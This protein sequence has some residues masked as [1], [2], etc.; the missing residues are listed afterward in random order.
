M[1]LADPVNLR[2]L[3]PLVMPFAPRVP[4]LVALF[5]LRL[6]AIE[7][8]E[9]AR[10]WRHMTEMSVTENHFEITDIP[11]YGQVHEV[12]RARMSGAL[13]DLIP[14]A[15]NDAALERYQGYLL[16]DDMDFSAA[17]DAPTEASPVYFSQSKP[18]CFSLI[19]FATG[20]VV[21]SLWLK[22]H[23]D[24]H[25][26]ATSPAGL[27][28]DSYDRVPGY[29]T[30]LYGQVVA[31]GALGRLLMHTTAEYANPDLAMSKMAAAERGIVSAISKSFSGQQ[32][33]PAR[34]KTLWT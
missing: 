33:A 17:N 25:S 6:A 2:V 34:T 3:L 21:M 7:L 28:E 9:R 24:K 29:L 10:V 8:C 1:A 15:S 16:S 18:G 14:L 20:A 12:E 4:E 23:L 31:D 26:Y 32:R 11:P 22:P 27:I 30:N 5:N 13:V 19:P